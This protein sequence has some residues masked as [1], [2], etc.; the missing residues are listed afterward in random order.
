ML[1]DG[2]AAVQRFANSVIAA[3][4]AGSGSRISVPWSECRAT[5][6]SADGTALS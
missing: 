2:V 1:G 5:N 3:I 4:M 6:N